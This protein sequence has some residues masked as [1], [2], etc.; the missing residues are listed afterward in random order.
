MS[1]A[2]AFIAVAFEVVLANMHHKT[3][4]QLAHL[5]VSKSYIAAKTQLVTGTTPHCRQCSAV[6]RS[7][8]MSRVELAAADCRQA[9]ITGSSTSANAIS[10]PV[11][12]KPL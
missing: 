2:E 5:V 4:Q 9:A 12:Y 7:V 3:V 6:K 10:H 1:C 8:T 11:V